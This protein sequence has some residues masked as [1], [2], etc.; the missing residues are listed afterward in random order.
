[1]KAEVVEGGEPPAH[2]KL[3]GRGSRIARQLR[4]ALTRQGLH[5]LA[6]PLKRR[7]LGKPRHSGR[8]RML[9]L[10]CF[11]QQLEPRPLDLDAAARDR[12]FVG[13]FKS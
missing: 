12:D 2:L 10:A 11:D 9:Q 8:S 5:D 3:I 1:M 13:L 4:L 7:L 6:K